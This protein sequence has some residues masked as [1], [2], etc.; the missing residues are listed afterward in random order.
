MAALTVSSRSAGPDLG[1]GSDRRLPGAEQRLE[2]V[3]R[4][5]RG[6][7]LAECTLEEHRGNLREQLQMQLG[8][9]FGNEEHED[10]AHRLAVR[11][12]EGNR[13]FQAHECPVC[14]PQALD[15]A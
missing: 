6:E 1:V 13:R 7:T 14:F 2:L 9:L 8:G 12:I 10:L 3:R 4:R 15:A 11:G 5:R